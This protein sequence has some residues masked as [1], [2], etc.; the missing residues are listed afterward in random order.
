MEAYIYIYICT[1]LILIFKYMETP[2]AGALIWALIFTLIP[3]LYFTHVREA[4][5]A[6]P[7]I[8]GLIF[9]LISTLILEL[10]LAVTTDLSTENPQGKKINGA[11]WFSQGN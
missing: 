6:G 11:E 2:V 8:L 7:L 3:G 5:A 9:T 1:V 10:A 4:P